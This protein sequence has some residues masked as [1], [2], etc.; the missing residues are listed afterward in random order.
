[1]AKLLDTVSAKK[2][3]TIRGEKAPAPKKAT[4]K[5]P[6]PVVN[7]EEATITVQEGVLEVAAKPRQRGRPRKDGGAAMLRKGPEHEEN[8]QADLFFAPV[9][10]DISTKDTMGIMDVAVYKLSKKDKRANDMVRYDLRDGWVIVSSGAYGMA[11]VW[12]YDIVLMGISYLTEAMNRYRHGKGE[13]PPQ[14]FRPHVSEILKFCRRENGGDQKSKLIDALDRL[15][16]TTV[17]MERIVTIKGK[18]KLLTS[19]GESLIGPYKA[20]SSLT[21]KK[22][23]YVEFRIP[24]WIYTEIVTNPTP[25]VLTVH[26]D[27][28]LIEPGTAKFIYRLARQKAGRTSAE[29][30]FRTIYERSGSTGSFKE[31]CR[32]VRGYI[33]ENNLPEYMLSESLG[34]DGPKLAM[35]HRSYA[36]RWKVEAEKSDW[37]VDGETSDGPEVEADS[38]QEESNA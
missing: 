28:F 2:A 12:D 4:A 10:Y 9:L 32:T 3:P 19:G 33:R 25:D 30:N 38:S 21:T 20:I 31:F 24:D 26:P 15:S 11:S 6:E 18:K 29:W 23:E 5:K 16:T 13:I 14:L 8:G 1:M 7:P 35:V 36:D 22:V 27:Y 37:E 17:K 34:A